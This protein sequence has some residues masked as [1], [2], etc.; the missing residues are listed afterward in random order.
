MISVPSFCARTATTGRAHPGGTRNS[1]ITHIRAT[2]ATRIAPGCYRCARQIER[3]FGTQFLPAEYPVRD[4]FQRAVFYFDEQRDVTP[5]INLK[6]GTVCEF[7]NIKTSGA[8]DA[9]TDARMCAELHHRIERENRRQI[10]LQE[11]A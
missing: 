2:V 8:H 10:L 9:L 7:F 1:I 4:V 5:P 3:T 11:R 6:L